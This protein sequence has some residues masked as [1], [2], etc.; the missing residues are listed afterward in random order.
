M[1]VAARGVEVDEARC[2]LLRKGVDIVHVEQ[3]VA[4]GIVEHLL[5]VG[6][7]NVAARA[8]DRDV[9][10][11]QAVQ[12]HRKEVGAV[13]VDPVDV[14]QNEQHRH[15]FGDRRQN[16]Q[17]ALKRGEIICARGIV[18]R[19]AGEI[20]LA[21]NGQAGEEARGGLNVNIR[22]TDIFRFEFRDELEHDRVP[23]GEHGVHLGLVARGLADRPAGK[24]VLVQDVVDEVCLADARLAL[25]QRADLVAFKARA[26]AQRYELVQHRVLADELLVAAD[27]ELV[28]RGVPRVDDLI[29]ERGG[30]LERGDAEFVGKVLAERMVKAKCFTE[31]LMVAVDLHERGERAFL[32]RVDGDVLR[33][34]LFGKV[35][36]AGVIGLLFRRQKLVEVLR[37]IEIALI[38]QPC[39]KR[40]GVGDI[41]VLQKFPVI[42]AEHVAALKIVDIA[43]DLNVGGEFNDRALAGDEGIEG[44]RLADGVDRVA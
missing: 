33:A 5:G 44:K 20:V 30:L 6:L 40:G 27:L 24:I 3:L 26:I 7:Q 38:A 28:G 37:L 12:Q 1:R 21:F 13:V 29:V 22:N 43:G 8:D 2:L 25:N 16:E 10:A 14:L 17:R 41:E 31:L 32:Q 19:N 35:E 36:L 9:R 15:L 23:R 11:A 34:V 42:G 4:H 18:A 39:V